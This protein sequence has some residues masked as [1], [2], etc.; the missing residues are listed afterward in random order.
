MLLMRHLPTPCYAHSSNLSFLMTDFICHSSLP[1]VVLEK[2]ALTSTEV[3][4]YPRKN[5]YHMCILV[6]Y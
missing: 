3:C 2:V 4:V 1:C 6:R 5:V